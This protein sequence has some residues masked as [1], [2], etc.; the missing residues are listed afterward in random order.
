LT[1]VI[2][3]D[4]IYVWI[5]KKSFYLY[6]FIIMLKIK[7]KFI[8]SSIVLSSV[9]ALFFWY[10]YFI[11]WTTSANPDYICV[12]NVSRSCTVNVS[13]CWAWNSQGTRYCPWSRVTAVWYYHTR[14]TCESWY[15][16]TW[17]TWTTAT[18]SSRAKDVN[19]AYLDAEWKKAT[20]VHPSSWRHSS[21]FTYSTSSCWITQQDT[22]PPIWTTSAN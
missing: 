19:S 8:L 11:I 14:T 5:I 16:A 12:K 9:S 17:P 4:L 3:S 20:T 1:K 7:N 18:N 6:N 15:S 13:N 22:T 21:D 2:L 10:F